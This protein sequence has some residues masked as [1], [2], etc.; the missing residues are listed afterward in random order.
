MFIFYNVFEERYSHGEVILV[1]SVLP[2]G[3]YSARIE[4]QQQQQ[5]QQQQ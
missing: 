3:T 2:T 1:R 4:Q 5:Q